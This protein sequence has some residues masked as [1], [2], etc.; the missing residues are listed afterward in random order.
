M[1]IL[2][3]SATKQEVNP[4]LRLLKQKGVNVVITGVGSAP[5]L[6]HILKAVQQYRPLLMIQA[7]IGGR[8]DRQLALGEVVAV[9]ED[10]FGDLGVLENRQWRSVF[11]LGFAQPN[12][13]PFKN[14]QLKNLHR[15][16]LKSCGLKCLPAVTV[17]EISTNKQSI[18]LLKEQGA[19]I[20]SMEGA[21]LHYVALMEKI[22]F[23]QIRS[24]SNDV[25]ERNK[26]KWNFTDAI[27]NLN[28]ELVR[29]IKQL[30]ESPTQQ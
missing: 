13:K 15:S 23:L 9:S 3:I 29:I 16:L 5:A 18:R 24:I 27:A 10:S 19:A 22:P 14:G 2:L 20:E 26:S 6:Y 28:K 11:D 12:Q 21:A 1:S 4:S 30:D 7:G 8:F 17:N 25:G